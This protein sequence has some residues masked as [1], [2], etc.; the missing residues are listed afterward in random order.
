MEARVGLDGMKVHHGGKEVY[1]MVHHVRDE[2]VYKR[3]HHVKVEAACMNF[4]RVKVEAA[5]MKVHHANVEEVC[6]KVPDIE[7]CHHNHWTYGACGLASDIDGQ[8]VQEGR[9][10]ARG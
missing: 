3:V 8:V 2:E 10:I 9:H 5:Y 4:H 6:M 1:M 7:A